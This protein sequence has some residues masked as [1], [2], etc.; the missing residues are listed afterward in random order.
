MI[1]SVSRRKRYIEIGV[2]VLLTIILMVLFYSKRR[3]FSNLS[4][5]GIQLLAKYAE[6]LQP[7][8][9]QIDYTNEDI[10]N[11]A[12][13]GNLPLNRKQDKYLILNSDANGK[14][15]YIVTDA[16]PKSEIDN[17]SKLKSKFE[18]NKTK[19]ELL[20]TILAESKLNLYKSIL[21]SDSETYAISPK[22]LDIQIELKREIVKL[23]KTDAP[24]FEAQKVEF[25]SFRKKIAKELKAN[26]NFI[27]V[28]PDTVLEIDNK[29]KR[30]KKVDA[31]TKKIV[32][33]ADDL[34]L[35]KIKD[36]S[37]INKVEFDKGDGFVSINVPSVKVSKN[38]SL[39]L[40]KKDYNLEIEFDNKGN[41]F[42]F[43]I[44]K[45]PKELY[46]DLTKLNVDIIKQLGIIDFDSNSIH[47]KIPNADSIKKSLPKNKK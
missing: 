47:I 14:L 33:A 21:F 2:L 5:K 44:D 43:N 18:L 1:E 41:E 15:K 28:N 23:T 10:V 46:V 3:Y 6:N 38:I 27:F 20:D 17:Y 40:S 16:V 22:V 32:V 12:L 31:N 13:Y 36:K 35:A 45:L 8:N 26:N 39:N 24:R 9:N 34:D 29:I 11:F 37:F 42:K 4:D 19:Q 7:I 25:N 30:L